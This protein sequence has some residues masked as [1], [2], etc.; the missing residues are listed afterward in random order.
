MDSGFFDQ[1]FTDGEMTLRINLYPHVTEA[2]EGAY[3][4]A[5]HVDSGFLTFVPSHNLAALEVQMADSWNPVG[6]HPGR[7]AVNAGAILER[8]SNGAVTASAHRVQALDGASPRVT[9]P[10][11]F[12]PS[13]DAVIEPMDNGLPPL[14]DPIR[15]GDFLELFMRSNLPDTPRPDL[16][17]E[18]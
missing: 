16:D 14:A 12:S 10:F 15:F 8:W 17:H 11:F 2:P 5:P 1:Y 18:S 9:T 6:N 13:R 7:L 4:M 3:R